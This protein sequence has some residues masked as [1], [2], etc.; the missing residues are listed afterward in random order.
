MAGRLILRR[1]YMPP[2]TIRVIPENEIPYALI[3]TPKVGQTFGGG[4]LF[5]CFSFSVLSVGPTQKEYTDP[6]VYG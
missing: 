3:C 5:V 2:V 6:V 1:I 4:Y